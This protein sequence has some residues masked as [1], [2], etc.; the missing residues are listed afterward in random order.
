MVGEKIGV[1]VSED[2]MLIAENGEEGI[3]IFSR[4]DNDDKVIEGM[5]RGILKN[6]AS[7]VEGYSMGVCTEANVID[8]NVEVKASYN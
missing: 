5:C 8:T 2:E 1:E 6:V 7:I 3:E 4:V